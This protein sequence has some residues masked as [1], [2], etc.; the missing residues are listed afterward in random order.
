MTAEE[1]SKV[2]I[3]DF[4]YDIIAALSEE[5]AV[6]MYQ[7]DVGDWVEECRPER[8]LSLDDPV[9]LE[10][11]DCG[12]KSTL[13]RCPF[14]GSTWRETTFRE[15]LREMDFRDLPFYIAGRE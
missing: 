5:D 12:I 2:R 15:L 7:K 8:E 4:G 14:C 10:N 13:R 9:I 3:F 6:K 1:I 11:A